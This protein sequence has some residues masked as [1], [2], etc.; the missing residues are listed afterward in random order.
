MNDKME[1]ECGVF[2]VF[3]S[4]GDE[5]A[6]LIYSG[7]LALQHRGQESA[8]ISVQTGEKIITRKSMGLVSEA[9][10][11]VNPENLRGTSGVGHVRYSTSGDKSL[12]N[13]QPLV[14]HCKLGDLAIAHNGNLVNADIIRSLM[15]DGGT[16]FQT[17]SDSEILLNLISR[18]ASSGSYD[19]AIRE[20][21]SAVKGSYSTIILT[22]DRLAAVR[23]PYGIRP[24]CIGKLGDVY[25]VSSETCALDAVGADFVR[26][27][28]PGELVFIDKNG[29]HSEIT[30]KGSEQNTCLFEYI[31]FARPDSVIDGISVYRF[32]YQSG[33]E[34]YNEHPVKADVV[35]GVPD[36]G[37]A[38]ALGYAAASGI[39]F[40]HGLIKNKYSGRSFIA[41]SKHLREQTVNVKLN[42]LKEEVNGKRVVLIDD[43]LV[44]GTTSKKLIKSL[45]KAGAA[46]VHL[47]IVSP[48]V[49][50]SCYFG[51]DTPYRTELIA[52]GKST[53]EI[54]QLIGADSLFYI[55]P[56]GVLKST[57][58]EKGF[59]MGC[60]NGTYPMSYS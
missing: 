33:M 19:K 5:T 27:I 18:G 43:S 32:R 44:R 40:T 50:H 21:A 46:E 11:A 13:A 51:I 16:V 37:L 28:E 35:V 34:L 22:E 41:P 30:G 58:K 20:A 54:C 36:S 23:D 9:F 57:G 49:T 1:E 14:G 25:I 45:R 6:S 56:E 3:G 53:E 10:K 60:F 29:I 38:A 12:T 52:A 26:D 7:L 55:S 17:T 4:S 24:L 48:P 47:G 42:V 39:P 59:C 15:E 2:G 31:Y 8:G